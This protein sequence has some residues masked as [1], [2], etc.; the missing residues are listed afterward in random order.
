VAHF[1]VQTDRFVDA[2]IAAVAARDRQL[3]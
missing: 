3:A 2:V 1:D